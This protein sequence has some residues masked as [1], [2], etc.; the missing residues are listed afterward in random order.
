MDGP[1][2]LARTLSQPVPTGARGVMWQYHSRSDR[3]SKVACWGILLDLM[4]ESAV[5]RQQLQTGQVTFGVNHEMRD[6]END[7]KKKLDLVLCRPAGPPARAARSFRDY[8]AKWGIRLTADEDRRVTSLPNPVEAPVGAVLAAVEAK[9]CM[10]AHQRALPRLFDELNS[11]HQIVHGASKRALAIG[12]AMVNVADAFVS[13]DL[14]KNVPPHVPAV[15]S[16]H[17]QPRDAELA[18]DTVKKL[19]RSSGVGERGF[20]GLAVVVIDMRNDGSAVAFVNGPPG[21]SPGTSDPYLY[22]N[23]IRRVAHEYD[24]AFAQI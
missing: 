7:K 19:R 18:V 6:W 10:T 22:D 12:F 23:T 15:V 1:H 9:A 20:D 24:A 4:S 11:S 3:H 5:L 16:V 8:I 17:N 2:I 14:N 13:P 21:P